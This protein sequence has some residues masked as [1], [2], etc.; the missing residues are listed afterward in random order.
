MHSSVPSFVESNTNMAELYVDI[1]LEVDGTAVR[2]PNF[3]SGL[4]LGLAHESDTSTVSFFII[5]HQHGGLGFVVWVH[6]GRTKSG[7]RGLATRGQFLF[8][9]H[10]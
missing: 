9:S 1:K 3:I 8:G 2:R 5:T 4:W 10:L 6:V 7:G